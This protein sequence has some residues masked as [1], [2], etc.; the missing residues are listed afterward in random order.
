MNTSFLRPARVL[1]C[2]LAAVLAFGSTAMAAD[3]SRLKERDAAPAMVIEQDTPLAVGKLVTGTVRGLGTALT[4]GVNVRVNP[5]MDA[6]VIGTLALNQSVIVLS[7]DGDWYR[8]SCEGLSGFVSAEYMSLSEEGEVTLDYGLVKDEAATVRVTPTEDA[9][10]MTVLNPDDAVTIVAVSGEWYQISVGDAFGYVRSDLVDPTA[11]VPAE[12]IFA[13]TVVNCE[14]A[15]LR[16]EPNEEAS[17]TDALF[18]GSL[19]T[20]IKQEGDWYQ[21]QYGDVTG[22]VLGALMKNTNNSADGS[23]TLETANQAAAREEAERKAAEAA[24]KK[25]AEEAA[26]RAA[27]AAAAKKP[28]TPSSTPSYTAPAYDSASS[29]DI[30]SVAKQYL[31]VPYVWGGTS[32][33]GFDCSG[34][35][36]YVFKKCGYSL[37]R[38]ASSQYGN[39][40]A[41][42]YSNLQAGDLVFFSGTYSASGIT[43]VGIYIGG[44][45]FIHAANGGVK[46]TSLSMSYYA[47]R[48]YGARRIA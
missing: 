28:S 32:P 25:A 29:S 11:E 40:T 47:S 18:S 24:A 12:K 19:C 45:Q 27:A 36:Q 10:E 17:K 34:F 8:I 13:Y 41:V 16:S 35:T 37:S 46:I 1:S 38:V 7:K 23:T 33:S 3:T 44:G 22:Y 26:K 9:E 42:S 30:V 15:N 31:G 14:A 43:H 21:V 48:Y 4:D 20:L 2:A 5:N 6:Y 39:G